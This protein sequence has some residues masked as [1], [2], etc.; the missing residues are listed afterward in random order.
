MDFKSSHTLRHTDTTPCPRR[1]QG[2]QEANV[3]RTFKHIYL[4]THCQPRCPWL[5]RF[6]RPSTCSCGAYATIFAALISFDTQDLS[7]GEIRLRLKLLDLGLG[8][9]ELA[10]QDGRAALLLTQRLVFI[11]SAMFRSW[12]YAFLGS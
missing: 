10:R 1:A 5:P 8:R 11:S 4:N 7:L 9:V 6:K 2:S 3:V 12:A